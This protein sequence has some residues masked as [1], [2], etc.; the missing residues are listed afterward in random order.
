MTGTTTNLAPRVDRCDAGGAGSLSGITSVHP[1][2]A[3]ILLIYAGPMT[4]R[5]LLIILLALTAVFSSKPARRK[6]AAEVLCLLLPG[7]RSGAAHR[8]PPDR[9]ARLRPPNP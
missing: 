1:T 4:L 7:R 8:D 3:L 9:P 5:G 6:A 2:F